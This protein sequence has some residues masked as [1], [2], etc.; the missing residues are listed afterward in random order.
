MMNPSNKPARVD[1]VEVAPRD[2]FQSI[3]EPLP[4]ADKIRCIQ[5]LVDAGMGR[6]EIGSFV[7]PKAIPQMADIGDIV[8]AFNGTP[9]VRFS[10]L[11]P[12]TKGAE[13]A[14]ASGIRELVY[15]VSVSETHN[16]KNVR[17]SVADSLGGLAAIAAL[18][19]EQADNE[20][21]LLRLDLGTCFDCPYEG[22]ISWQQVDAVLEQALPLLEGID[23]E[24]AMCDTTGRANPYQVADH[25]TRIREKHGRDNIRWAFHG[26]DTFGMGVA[27]ALFAI[28]H[29]A[30]ALDV[31]A[32]GLGGCPFAPG[33]TGNTATEDVLYALRGGGIETGIDMQKLLQAADAIAEL[34]GGQTASHLR[35]V[36]RERAA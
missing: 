12:N 35:K 9:G 10:A 28:H 7:S 29:G 32:A 1:I 5:A 11:V 14:L 23:L 20:T 22:Y 15:V 16:Q 3:Y 26:H 34:P 33:A 30:T 2:G 6:I 18:L 13:L 24:I 8:K 4:T 21:P 27:N 36:P 31:A 25:F 19:R 17:Q